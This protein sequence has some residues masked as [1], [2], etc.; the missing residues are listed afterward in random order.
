MVMLADFLSYAGSSPLERV[1]MNHWSDEVRPY[2]V[3]ALLSSVTFYMV[4]KGIR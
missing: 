3:A 1:T 4:L 2:L